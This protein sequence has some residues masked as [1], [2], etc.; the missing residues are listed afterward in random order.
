[1][2][3]KPTTVSVPPTPPIVSVPLRGNGF[4]TTKSPQPPRWTAIKVSVPLRGNGFETY[5]L[6]ELCNNSSYV[7]VPLRGN[8]FETTET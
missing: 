4:E 1:M 3:L 8:G 2:G 7:S 6:R 5:D